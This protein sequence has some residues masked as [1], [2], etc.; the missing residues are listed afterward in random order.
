MLSACKVNGTPVCK[1][2]E[3]R[4]V[5]CVCKSVEVSLFFFFLQTHVPGACD[6]ACVHYSL[7]ML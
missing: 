1:P 2:L 3:R 4:D 7:K 5:Q 6:C